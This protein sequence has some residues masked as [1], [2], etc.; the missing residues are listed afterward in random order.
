MIT[1][2]NN[3]YK[4]RHADLPN[5]KSD[6]YFERNDYSPMED[7]EDPSYIFDWDRKSDPRYRKAKAELDRL[8][9]L[10]YK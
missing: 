4:N 3:K 7:N 10:R 9:N 6:D 8:N 5:G 2:S 1:E